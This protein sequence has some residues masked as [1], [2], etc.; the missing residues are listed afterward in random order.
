MKRCLVA[1]LAAILCQG[2]A[3]VEPVA[4]WEKGDL[5]RPAMRFDRDRLEAKLAAHVY[6]SR[7]GASGAGSVGGGG[8]GCN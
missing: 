2:C 8:C 3:L 4:A 1:M 5:A 6:D 7:E